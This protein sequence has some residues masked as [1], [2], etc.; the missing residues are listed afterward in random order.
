VCSSTCCE[1]HKTLNLSSAK[2]L[3]TVSI[4]EKLKSDGSNDVNPITHVFNVWRIAF[5]RCRV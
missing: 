4:L 2:S 5:E 3:S 1:P